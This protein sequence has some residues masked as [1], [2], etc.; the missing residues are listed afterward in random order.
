MWILL[1]LIMTVAAPADATIEQAF[2]QNGALGVVSLA[3][4][5]EKDEGAAKAVE[6][7]ATAAP[8]RGALARL[9]EQEP[10][11]E[12]TPDRFLSPSDVRAEAAFALASISA[13]PDETVRLLLVMLKHSD[14]KIRIGSAFGLGKMGE[15][16]QAAIPAL[17][18]QLAAEDMTLQPAVCI[19]SM[20]PNHAAAVA[21]VGIGP[22]SIPALIEALRADQPRVRRHAADALWYFGTEAKPAVEPLFERLHDPDVEVRCKAIHALGWIAPEAE[23]LVSELVR[24]THDEHAEVRFHAVNLL[25]YLKPSDR[26]AWDDFVRL[27]DDPDPVVVETA[28]DGLQRLAP[29]AMAISAIARLL[30]SPDDMI[31]EAAIRTLGGIGHEAKSAIPALSKLLN[32]DEPYIR[33][34]AVEALGQ[35][36]PDAESAVPA[37]TKL[38]KDENPDVRQAAVEALGQMGPDA[39]SAVAAIT[40]LLKD[41]NPEVRRTAVETLGQMGPDAESA[42]AAITKLLK[43]ENPRVRQAADLALEM[44]TEEL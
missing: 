10:S 14:P 26:V 43:D 9:L 39:E 40:K 28:L 1:M 35:M 6:L 23:K 20:R 29:N 13:E 3:K 30:K 42:V 33:R 38:L 32:D 2:R 12:T 18:E 41:E 11:S 25:S 19:F 4:A 8:A 44:I 37:I 16:S 7:G 24:L 31:R 34:A 36:G 27:L 21:L 22:M 15:K 17:I 5:I